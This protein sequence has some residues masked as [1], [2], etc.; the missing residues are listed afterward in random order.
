MKTKNIFWGIFF[1][2]AAAF[3]VLN[4]T[5]H[6][7][8]INIWGLLV[9]LIFVPVIVK[10]I[11][12]LEFFGIFVPLSIIA[13]I[14]GF[15]IISPWSLVAVAVLLSI[16]LSFIFSDRK[17][18]NFTYH[19]K[20]ENGSQDGNFNAST[21][22]ENENV[23]DI[24]TNFAGS[25]KYINSQ[26]LERVNV[27]SSFGGTKIYFD[28]ARLLGDSA[29]VDIDAS[30]SGVELYVPG[31]WKIKNNVDCTM[32]G[33][34]EKGIKKSSEQEKTLVLTG[35]IRLAGITIIYI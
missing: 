7:L 17:N 26:S 13:C 14:F 12:H 22:E 34:D 19:S 21:S 20:I 25:V 15:T 4:Q 2:A 35:Y 27:H 30:F 33:V 18:T 23:V 5:G 3:L 24:Y 10:S 28:N 29:V 11:I 1:I 16:G 8:N 6:F 32:A 9:T 31:N